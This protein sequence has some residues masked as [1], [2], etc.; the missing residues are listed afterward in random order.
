[1]DIYYVGYLVGGVV[2]ICDVVDCGVEV[3]WVGFEVVEVFGL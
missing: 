2:C 1:V 3:D